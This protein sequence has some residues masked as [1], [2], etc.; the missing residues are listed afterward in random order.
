MATLGDLKA[1]IADE[2]LRSDLTAQIAKAITTAI[3]YYGRQEFY[4]NEVRSTALSTVAAQEWYTSSDLDVIATSPRI[5]SL[6]L[7]QDTTR[8]P[9]VKRGFEYIE[10]RATDTQSGGLPTDWAYW[11]KQIRLWPIPDQVWTVTV[12]YV[13]RLAAPDDD[14][15]SNAWTLEDDAEELIRSHAKIDLLMNVIRRPDMANDLAV[16]RMQD[17]AALAALRGEAASR[18]ATGYVVATQ[19]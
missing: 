16:L 10:K 2:L 8:Y 11:R 14:A 18:E 6:T 7:V 3:A 1:R 4:F 13:E 5:V 17:Q 15:S 19:W 9:L 12:N